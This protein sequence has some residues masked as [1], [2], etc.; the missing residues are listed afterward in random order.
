MARS[1]KKKSNLWHIVF[2]KFATPALG[3]HTLTFSHIDISFILSLINGTVDAPKLTT[4]ILH[5]VSAY[6]RN[7]H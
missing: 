5:R 4:S 2:K 3:I 6:P 7:N 1:R